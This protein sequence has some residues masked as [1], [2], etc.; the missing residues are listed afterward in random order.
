MLFQCT[1]KI[2]VFC[3]TF[4]LNS[5]IPSDLRFKIA[6]FRSIRA[7]RLSLDIRSNFENLSLDL[8][9]VANNALGGT[10]LLNYCKKIG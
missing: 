5:L 9:I 7:T 3:S 10:Q 6:G 4:C 1:I 8:R 2:A